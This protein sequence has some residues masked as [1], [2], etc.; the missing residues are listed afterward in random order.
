MIAR[1]GAYQLLGRIRLVM[2]ALV[3]A[4]LIA[5]QG[6]LAQE[7]APGDSPAQITVGVLAWRGAARARAQW[8]PTEAALQ[9]AFPA[10]QV[11]LRPLGLDEMDKA[12]AS[13]ALD[14][15]ITNPGEYTEMETRYGA[16]RLVTLETVQAGVPGASVGA[17][18]FTRADRR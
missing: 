10:S 12:L 2:I 4:L 3:S 15:F 1:A 5:V 18:I 9:R 17:V 14:F 7:A 13:G 11:V 8:A 6:G 16:A